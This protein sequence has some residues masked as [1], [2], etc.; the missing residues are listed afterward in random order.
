MADTAYLDWPFLDDR[1]RRLAR[2]LDA[3]ARDHV[4]HHHGP[5]VDAECRALPP[6]LLDRG[7]AAVQRTVEDKIVN[8]LG[9]AGRAADFT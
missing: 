2:E 8:F 4:P 5:D 6:E 1:H 7:R 9:S 3:W